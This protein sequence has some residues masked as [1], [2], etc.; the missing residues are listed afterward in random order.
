MATPPTLP[1][2][3]QFRAWVERERAWGGEAVRAIA[4]QRRLLLAD[5]HG[6]EQFTKRMALVNLT[7][8]V[9]RW[10]NG[11]SAG[12]K[13]VGHT[14]TAAAF[15]TGPPFAATEPTTDDCDALG[16]YVEARI[17]VLQDFLASD[18]AGGAG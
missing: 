14:E 1:I 6:L 12:F 15:A 13:K 4:R 16:E 2:T 10:G 11:L 3:P 17:K 18:A 5:T 9:A 8:S 7:G